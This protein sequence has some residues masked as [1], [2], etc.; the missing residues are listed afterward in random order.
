MA[1]TGMS[2][3]H[4]A[5]HGS[6]SKNRKLNKYMGYT[7]NL[8]GGST[9]LW[10]I[11]H[12][13]LHHTYPNVVE[14][15]DDIDPPFFLRFSPH[16]KRHWMH[17]F[18]HLYVWF[19]YGMSTLS[20]VTANDFI[21]MNR[22]RKMGYIKGKNEFAKEL[23]NLTGW[24]LLY[25]TY[26]LVLPLV[27]IPLAPWMII[28]GFVAMH[29]VTGFSL[30]IVFQTAHIMP[31]NEF[32]KPDDNGLIANSWSIHQLATTSNYAPNGRLFSWFIGGL[33][34]QIEHHLLP[35]VCHVHY[36][37]LSR[38]VADTAK[39]YGIPYHTKKTF[40]AALWDHTK[41]LAQLGRLEMA[42]VRKG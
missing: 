38:I 3:M 37:K 9:T 8:L 28:L 14:S 31:S 16:A 34:Y 5:M 6:Y 15:D 23:L 36:R 10:R 4:D 20:W 24:K 30:S 39:E 27:M 29:F 25:Y 12:N 19:F 13:V 11:Q 1:G 2:V 42:A 32:P 21:R 35:D 22:Y 33:N 26:T 40:I 7:M 18:Q 41:M 17:R